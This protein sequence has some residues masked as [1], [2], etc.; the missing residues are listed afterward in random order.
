MQEVCNQI[1]ASV[2]K[3]PPR[4]AS[5]RS[6]DPPQQL[7]SIP[8][9]HDEEFNTVPKYMKGRLTREKVNGGVEFLNKVFGD[10]YTLLKQ[11]P[12]K[13]SVEMRQRFY[14]KSHQDSSLGVGVTG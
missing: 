3:A 10:K 2:E 8:D 5:S 14:V 6:S 7:P 11:N 4:V 12:A 9:V 1:L 13:L